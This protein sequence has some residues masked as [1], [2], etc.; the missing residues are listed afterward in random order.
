V[1][2]YLRFAIPQNAADIRTVHLRRDGTFRPNPG[3]RWFPIQGQQ[4]FTLDP[5]GF[6]WHARIRMLPLLWIEARDSLISGQG[7]MLV[8]FNS[9][10]TIANAR[11]PEIDQG[12]RARWLAEAVWFPLAFASERIRWEPIDDRS[13]RV[14]LMGDGL[15]VSLAVEFDEEGRASRV[16]GERYRAVEGGKS[17]LT[18]WSASCTDYRDF[19]GLQVPSRVEVSWDLDEGQ[20]TYARFRVT[21]LEYHPRTG[22]EACPTSPAGYPTAPHA[23]AD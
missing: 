13:A 17:V 15:P 18:P 7:G 19:S 6:F 3:P 12:S 10:L 20:F 2:R 4:Y 22:Q 14:T 21:E 8:K 5:P 9:I 23:T 11:G 16:R 1:R